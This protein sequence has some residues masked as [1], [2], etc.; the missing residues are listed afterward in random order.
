MRRQTTVENG[1]HIVPSFAVIGM[2]GNQAIL[3]AG[4]LMKNHSFTTRDAHVFSNRVINFWNKLPDYVVQAPSTT[5][6]KKRLFSFVNS[7]GAF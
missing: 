4:K 3:P 1:E 7:L 2:F 5:S 6:F